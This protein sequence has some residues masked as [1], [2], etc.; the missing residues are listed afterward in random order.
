MSA[1]IDIRD[2]RIFI[3]SL[4]EVFILA[5]QPLIRISPPSSLRILLTTVCAISL[6]TSK[7]IQITA[8][9]QTPK[10]ALIRLSVFIF[11][12]DSA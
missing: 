9:V 2:G 11:G 1:K 7:L 4:W 8:P 10:I 5:T 12:H 6:S 3:Y